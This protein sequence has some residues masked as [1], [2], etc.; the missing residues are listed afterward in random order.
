MGGKLI[1]TNMR[2]QE[3]GSIIWRDGATYGYLREDDPNLT[4][5][6][7]VRDVDYCSA[8]FLMVRTTLLRRLGGYDPR[9]TPAYF[10]DADLCVRILKAGMRIVY[11]P[12]VVIEHLEFGSSGAVGSHA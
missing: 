3:A 4:T 7:F 1:R 11:D 5:A 6:N 9:Y 8:A 12:D 2:L 10:E